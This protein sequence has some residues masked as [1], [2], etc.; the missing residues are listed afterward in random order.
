MI[1]FQHYIIL[2]LRDDSAVQS[3][4]Y[5]TSDLGSNL[6]LYST[7]RLPVTPISGLQHPLQA[8]EA[9]ACMWYRD[10]HTSNTHTHI[11][12]SLFSYTIHK[13]KLSNADLKP[14]GSHSTET[15]NYLLERFYF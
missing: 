4:G 13:H 10:K 9:T 3:T 15:A 8:S 2:E 14:F 5:S 7:P 1:S 6:S 11:Y 12:T